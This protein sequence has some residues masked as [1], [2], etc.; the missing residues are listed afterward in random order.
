MFY[1]LIAVALLFAVGSNAQNPPVAGSP[2]G[3]GFNFGF[4]PTDGAA[5]PA[6]AAGL[7]AEVVGAQIGWV[8]EPTTTSKSAKLGIELLGF[9]DPEHDI[10][11][12]LTGGPLLHAHAQGGAT[13]IAQWDTAAQ[14]YIA[15]IPG[16]T[17]DS[18]V[19]LRMLVGFDTTSAELFYEFGHR[20][21][22]VS[23]LID[24]E[25]TD[26]VGILHSGV[27]PVGVD[28][29]DT[30]VTVQVA[31]DWLISDSE[32]SVTAKIDGAVKTVTSTTA[33]GDG[34]Y[35]VLIANGGAFV[36]G[37]HTVQIRVVMPYGIGSDYESVD[38]AVAAAL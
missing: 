5:S 9:E 8:V 1:P 16:G 24:V 35:D 25:Y 13:F 33:N 6:S 27:E 23:D 32:A 14:K 37:D 28:D 31:S 36:E 3:L 38:L 15:T 21:G 2:A 26:G 7:G 19:H 4:T 10:Y 17:F 22:Y 34:T 12:V 29:A 20:N 30:S 11:I 18:N